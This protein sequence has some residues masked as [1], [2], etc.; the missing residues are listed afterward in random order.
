MSTS[1]EQINELATALAKAQAQITSASH[2]GLNP[3]FKSKYST[4]DSVWKAC[5]APLTANGLSIVQLIS[6]AADTVY[7]TTKLM[8]SSGQWLSSVI[9]VMI[10][11]STPQALGSSL[12]YLKRYSIASMIGVT[13]GDEDDDANAAQ[14]HSVN[15]QN[16]PQSI[17]EFVQELRQKTDFEYSFENMEFYLQ[18]LA[19]QKSTSV[20]TIMEQAK[21]PALIERFCKGWE[22]WN[23]RNSD[24]P[25]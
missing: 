1:S 6:Y 15:I 4:L 7:L 19:S 2:D 18:K 24:S 3:H 16:R 10:G 25:I 11:K 22:V 14:Q 23:K 20:Q 12:T 21:T 13:S 8:H 17:D 5:R 9:P